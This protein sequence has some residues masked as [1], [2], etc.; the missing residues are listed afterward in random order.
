MIQWKTD[1]AGVEGGATAQ[2]YAIDS[3]GSMDTYRP[4]TSASFNIPCR[5]KISGDIMIVTYDQDGEHCVYKGDMNGRGHFELHAVN[6]DGQ[7]TLHFIENDTVLEGSWL[8]G[9]YGGM[10][11]IKLLPE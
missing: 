6:F 5:V 1:L 3:K 4:H 11:K 7:A 10:W 2:G 9:N 8:E